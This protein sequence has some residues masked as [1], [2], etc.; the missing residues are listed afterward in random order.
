MLGSERE[1]IAT[2]SMPGLDTP[3]RKTA[4]PILPNPFKPTLIIF[5]TCIPPPTP[6]DVINEK[7]LK[8][9]FVVFRVELVQELLEGTA[10]ERVLPQDPFLVAQ[11]PVKGNPLRGV[12]QE[13]LRPIIGDDEGVRGQVLEFRDD[14]FRFFVAQGIEARAKE[15]GEVLVVGHP[16]PHDFRGGKPEVEF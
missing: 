11:E 13:E 16:F 14:D 6:L 3:A 15:D 9:L 1:F 2:N 7:Q 12:Q 4:L 8:E 10:L 5:S